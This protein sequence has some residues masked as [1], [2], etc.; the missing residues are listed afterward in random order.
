VFYDEDVESDDGASGRYATYAELASEY[1]ADN[2]REWSDLNRTGSVSYTVIQ[3]AYDW[4]TGR[5]D[6]EFTR[7]PFLT[8]LTLTGA[9]D[10]AVF[11]RWENELAAIK[12][13]GIRPPAEGTPAASMEEMVAPILRRV[14]EYVG[15]LKHFGTAPTYSTTQQR[16][17]VPVAGPGGYYGRHY[18]WRGSAG[19]VRVN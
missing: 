3:A 14:R 7:S 18:E 4:A 16:P 19:L 17:N 10:R 8:P 11:A 12:L 1:G 6:E 9:A 5:I 13:R 15:G 2:L